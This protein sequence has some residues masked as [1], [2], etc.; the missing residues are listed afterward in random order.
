MSSCCSVPPATSPVASCSPVCCTSSRP[1]CCED[2]RIVGTSLDDLDTEQFVKI[3]REAVD[4]FSRPFDE[5]CWDDF[6]GR[7][8]FVRQSDGPAAL[9]AAVAVAEAAAR[10]G[11]RRG[12]RPAALPQRPAEGGAAR[13]SSQLA[14]A[15]LVERSRIIMEKPFGTD[16]ESAK[17]LNARLHE[18]FARSRSSA[19]TT[20]S[21]RRRPRTSWPSGSRTAC[22]SRSGT[23]TSSTTSR[24]TCRRPSAWRCGPPSTSPP[25]RSATWWSPT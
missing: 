17:K 23:A 10:P 20:S 13:S 6:A 15:G 9:A 24:S 12:D 5:A 19:S 14:E 4:E 22:S 25:A 8:S 16:L 2:C 3:A 21:A 7:L 18:V 1:G 11:V